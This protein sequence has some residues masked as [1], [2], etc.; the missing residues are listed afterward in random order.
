MFCI[1]LILQLATDGQNYSQPESKSTFI[2]TDAIFI[3]FEQIQCMLPSNDS[4]YFY[5]ATNHSKTQSTVKFYQVFNSKC[6]KCTS[7]GKCLLIIVSMKFTWHS[8]RFNN[9]LFVKTIY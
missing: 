1:Y 9:F 2:K 5:I 3:S 4:F 8:H 6:F 7:L